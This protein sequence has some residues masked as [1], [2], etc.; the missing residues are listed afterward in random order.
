LTL[1]QLERDEIGPTQVTAI[2]RYRIDLVPGVLAAD[3]TVGTATAAAQM[4]ANHFTIERRP[5]ALDSD[6]PTVEL[7]REV[8]ALM[9]VSGFKTETPA[10][11][12]SQAIASS[13]TLPL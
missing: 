11:A 8:V 9:L 3:Q 10:L 2:G 13:A 12:N 5:L 7:Q 6:K 4:H 1:D